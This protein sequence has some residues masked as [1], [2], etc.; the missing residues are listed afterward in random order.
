MAGID[1]QIDPR[2]ARWEHR[3]H[4][5]VL[6]AAWVALPTVFLYFAEKSGWLEVLVVVVSWGIWLTFLAE[7]VIMLTVVA[8]RRAW[9]RG[10]LFG[11]AIL[12]LTLPALTHI[13]EGLLAARA[14][15]SLQGARVLQVLYLAKALKIVKSA[16]VVRTKGR[17]PR[18]P[19]LLTTVVL[20][21]S[22][23][24]VGIVHK[25]VTH[26]KRDKTP[27]HGFWYAIDGLP[28]WAMAFI[29]A[30][31]VAVLLGALTARTR[32]PR[33]AGSERR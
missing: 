26:D 21:L 29:A 23:V 19:V 10:H 18:H 11:L 13:L 1:P 3:L 2:G 25:I 32:R 9:I 16:Q 4:W 6:I 12:V 33:Q 7:A 17:E 30:G 5:P 8:N 31:V 15:S 14:L 22:V 24:L 20:V 28:H 27:L